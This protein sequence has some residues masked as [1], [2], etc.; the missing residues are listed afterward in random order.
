LGV[1][2][3]AVGGGGG[4]G[5]LGGGGGGRVSAPLLFVGRGTKQRS[6]Q[7]A[8][9]KSNPKATA[10]RRRLNAGTS[11]LQEPRTFK[12]KR[13]VAKGAQVKEEKTPRGRDKRG[14]V[15]EKRDDAEKR[16]RKTVNFHALREPWTRARRPAKGRSQSRTEKRSVNPPTSVRGKKRERSD[17]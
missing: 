7:L 4:G 16:N 3:G 11:Q 1:F 8:M 2:V 13:G 14:A 5:G 17:L 12:K 15:Q 9:G 10:R 6:T